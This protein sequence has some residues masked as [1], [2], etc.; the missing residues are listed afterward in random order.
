VKVECLPLLP[1]IREVPES[2]LGP[3]NGYPVSVV[4]TISLG[5]Y[6]GTSN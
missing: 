2:H 4:S 3:E 1:R 6:D 5:K